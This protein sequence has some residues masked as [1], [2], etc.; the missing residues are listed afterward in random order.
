MCSEYVASNHGRC[1]G[2]LS[3][4]FYDSSHPLEYNVVIVSRKVHTRLQLLYNSSGTSQPP[5]MVRGLGCRHR[6]IPKQ[7]SAQ[8]AHLQLIPLLY[9]SAPAELYCYSSYSQ[10]RRKTFFLT[11]FSFSITA[12]V[13]FV[14][15]VIT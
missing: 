4:T 3:Q 12:H 14:S 8:A 6:Q 2:Y 9:R 11:T 1:T 5:S 15:G 7:H 10:Q 13:V